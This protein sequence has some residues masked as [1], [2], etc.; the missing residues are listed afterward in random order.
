MGEN[1]EKDYDLSH[2]RT[3]G[4]GTGNFIS[5]GDFRYFCRRSSAQAQFFHGKPSL[6]PESGAVFPFRRR[7]V[8]LCRAGYLSHEGADGDSGRSKP[9][10]QNLPG[11]KRK[12]S[13]PVSFAARGRSFKLPF[14]T[15]R[16]PGTFGV[17]EQYRGITCFSDGEWKQVLE[18]LEKIKKEMS[19]SQSASGWSDTEKRTAEGWCGCI[20]PSCFCF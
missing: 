7:A 9:D 15:L 8:L 14:E 5:G 17:G 2:L 16:F 10:S 13:S 3:V 12:K 1:T 19:M 20:R 18:Q 6:S 4:R 11:R